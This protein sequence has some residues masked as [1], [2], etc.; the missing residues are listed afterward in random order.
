MS[1]S[2]DPL[3]LGL[4][5]AFNVENPGGEYSWEF[6]VCW[7]CAARS[8]NPD[9]IEDPKIDIFHLASKIYTRFQ[10]WHRQKLCYHYLE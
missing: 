8:T 2:R 3:A 5:T 1:V 6:V 7:G 9:P 4:T 10:T